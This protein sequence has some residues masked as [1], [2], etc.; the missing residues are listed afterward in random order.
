MPRHGGPMKVGEKSKDFKGT[1]IKLFKSLN[2]W[3]SLVIISLLL[4]LFSALLSTIAPN[5]LSKLTDVISEGIKPNAVKIQEISKEIYS[6]AMKNYIYYLNSIDSNNDFI[7]SDSKKS[8]VDSDTS[9]LIKGFNGLDD[10]VKETILKDIEIDGVKISVKDQIKFLNIVNTMNDSMVTEDLLKLLD[11]L[12]KSIKMLVEP[13][14][15]M[16]KVK[17]RS[18]VLAIIYILSSIFGYIQAYIMATISNNYARKLRSD[19]SGKINKLPLK[20][21]DNHETGDIL[22]RVTNDVDSIGMNMNQ[23]L[24]TLVSSSTLFLGSIVM[25]FITNYLMALTAI[26]AS[27]MGFIGSFILL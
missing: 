1:M 12:P 24:A 2:K 26:A 9:E 15:N 21:F 3:K 25:M 18:L 8:I 14:M 7:N 17:Y 6:N 23:S 13:K 5:R 11:K 27:I 4:A 10:D 16:N 19:I 22:S 20:Y